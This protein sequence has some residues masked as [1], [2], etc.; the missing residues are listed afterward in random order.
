MIKLKSRAGKNGICGKS[1]FRYLSS[2]KCSI[3]T[4]FFCSDKTITIYFIGYLEINQNAPN[5]LLTYHIVLFSVLMNDS[6]L[7][8]DNKFY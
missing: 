8:A 5:Q 4:T 6:K 1:L 2:L 7:K 3:C